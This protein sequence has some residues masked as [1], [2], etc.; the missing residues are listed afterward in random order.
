MSQT[1][2]EWEAENREF[3]AEYNERIEREGT[4]LPAIFMLEEDD[5]EES[6]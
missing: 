5:E 6:I 3:I 4:A 2:E 1:K